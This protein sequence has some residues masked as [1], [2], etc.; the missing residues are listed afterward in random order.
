MKVRGF[1]ARV[2]LSEAQLE[3]VERKS[4]VSM[5]PVLAVL[6]WVGSMAAAAAIHFSW[7][8]S[9]ASSAPGDD[10]ATGRQRAPTAE[11]AVGALGSKGAPSSRGFTARDAETARRAEAPAA[12]S[13]GAPPGIPES[14][15]AIERDRKIRGS[16]AGAGRDWLAG[17]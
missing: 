1:K 5:A 11:G 14:K 17:W 6:V 16:Y 10:E 7:T 15:R 9:V 13:S 8:P 2:Q 12:A 4:G 3:H